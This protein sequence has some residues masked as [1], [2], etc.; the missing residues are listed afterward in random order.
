MSKVLLYSGGTDS[1]LIDKIWKPDKKIYI[2]IHGRY[3]KEEIEKLP[4]DV[5]IVDFP[6]LGNTE[7][8]EN[9][10]VPLRNLF[11]L[12]I[13]KRYGDEI[14]LGATA[15]DIGNSDKTP[16]FL[17][18][19]EA[20]INECDG[21]NTCQGSGDIKICMDFVNKS[22]YEL[23]EEYIK[24]GGTVEFF[25]N[26][27]FSCHNPKDGKECM[28]CKCCYKKFLLGYYFGYKYDKEKQQKIINRLIKNELSG[29]TNSKYF[30]FDRP[31]EGKYMKIAVEK[32]FKENNLN[33]E[34]YL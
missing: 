15:G 13:A 5:E 16:Q 28:E 32:L 3:S 19:A 25:I 12:M 11:F 26:D 9:A 14:C 18:H 6:Y 33:L 17:E 4:K 34:E 10:Y 29:N 7:R 21:N 8:G 22:K 1:W 31:G 2:N 30:I 20:I 27:T 24:Q 23:L